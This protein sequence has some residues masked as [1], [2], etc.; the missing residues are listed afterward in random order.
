[1][2]RAEELGR[3]GECLTLFKTDATDCANCQSERLYWHPRMQFKCKESQTEENSNIVQ[4]CQTEL[5]ERKTIIEDLKNKILELEEELKRANTALSEV[6]KKW[7]N[8]LQEKNQELKRADKLDSLCR[9]GEV[10]LKKLQEQIG[11]KD[12][13]LKKSQEQISHKNMELEK[14]RLLQL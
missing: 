13:D 2:H 11:Q 5:Q 12:M 9:N 14:H 7:T 3:C 6:G 1:M 4:E 10:E 8:T